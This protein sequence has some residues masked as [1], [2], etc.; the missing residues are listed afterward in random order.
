MDYAL[1]APHGDAAETAPGSDVWERSFASGT[2][3]VWDNGKRRGNV[4]WAGQPPPP[5]PPPPAPVV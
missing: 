1:G 3:V 2:R 4:T 5:P